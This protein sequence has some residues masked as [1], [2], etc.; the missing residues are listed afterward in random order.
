[1]PDQ[2]HH[3][4]N[5]HHHQG[6]SFGN[7][8]EFEQETVSRSNS[9][10]SFVKLE[11]MLEAKSMKVNGDPDTG[12]FNTREEQ[13]HQ[14][15]QSAPQ[16]SKKI[17]SGRSRQRINVVARDDEYRGRDDSSLDFPER[18]YTIHSKGSRQ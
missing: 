3:D 1:M 4:R 12:A 7:R 2:V 11:R 15:A 16:G 9:A 10:N 14:I 17:V 8:G 5:G 6:G 18:K 13:P